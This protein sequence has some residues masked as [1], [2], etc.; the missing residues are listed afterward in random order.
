MRQDF[1]LSC[2]RITPRAI[3]HNARDI[4]DYMS[5]A[6]TESFPFEQAIDGARDYRTLG[7]VVNPFLVAGYLRDTHNDGKDVRCG[8]ISSRKLMQETA[9]GRD[10]LAESGLDIIFV[11]KRAETGAPARL[12]A[13]ASPKSYCDLMQMADKTQS[14]SLPQPS[15]A[16]TQTNMDEAALSFAPNTFF[17]HI[18]K[19]E[20]GVADGMLV[21]STDGAYCAMD[22]RTALFLKQKLSPQ[23][24]DVIKD[25]DTAQL[26][27]GGLS[28]L[29]DLLAEGKFVRV[30][31]FSTGEYIFTVVPGALGEFVDTNPCNRLGIK[32]ADTLQMN[33][34]VR[35]SVHADFNGKVFVH[36]IPHQERAK[37]NG[38]IKRELPFGQTSLAMNGLHA[39]TQDE[40]SFTFA[41]REMRLASTA[42]QRN[43]HQDR[44][45]L[46]FDSDAVLSV[47]LPKSGVV[48]QASLNFHDQH[49]LLELALS[50]ASGVSV[51]MNGDIL[52]LEQS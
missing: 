20:E 22:C 27:N 43:K 17:K 1:C 38:E 13:I 52:N 32:A 46:H 21:S 34:N 5:K 6:G 25:I 15:K 16:H 11:S 26:A 7:R 45:A 8:L 42:R 29:D 9:G 51:C 23:N 14:S 48:S 24:G 49:D 30:K 35:A 3:D 37:H 2:N 41:G 39:A 18:S 33:F 36:L 31:K 50:R 28:L 4:A 40:G 10:Y 12:V 44:N 47:T 19:V